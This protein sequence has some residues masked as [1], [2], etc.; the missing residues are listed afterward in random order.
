MN[1]REMVDE[2]VVDMARNGNSASLI[3]AIL[4]S[5]RAHDDMRNLNK[6]ANDRLLLFY[7]AWMSSVVGLV[8]GSSLEFY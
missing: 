6:R 1:S 5:Q 8:T 3:C 4:S 7:V 2:L